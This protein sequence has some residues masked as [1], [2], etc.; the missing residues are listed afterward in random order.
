M[1]QTI[2]ER[3]PSHPRR[4][5]INPILKFALEVGQLLV[6]FFANARGA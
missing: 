4:K 3:D 2:L 5:E 1:N 6:F